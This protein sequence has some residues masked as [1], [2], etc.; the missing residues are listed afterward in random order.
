MKRAIILKSTI[1]T[2]L[3]ATIIFPVN[4]QSSE[5]KKE[6]KIVKRIERPKRPSKIKVVDSFVD[7]S[8]NLYNKVFIYDSLSI[9]EVKIPAELEDAIVDG[10]QQDADSLMQI[11]P[12]VID[13]MEGEKLIRKAKAMLNLNK[14]RRILTYSVKTAKLYAVREIGIGE[15]STKN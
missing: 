14:V 12:E 7:Y 10:V 1:L 8:F 5:E 13:G 4:A 3:L 11:I 15:E 6:R 9:R 2:I